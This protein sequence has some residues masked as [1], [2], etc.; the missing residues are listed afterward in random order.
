ML[1]IT[2]ER[3]KEILVQA[4]ESGWSGCLELK[5]EYADLVLDGMRDSDEGSGTSS[6]TISTSDN[7]LFSQHYSYC[8]YNVSG[9][10]VLVNDPEEEI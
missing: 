7:D 10:T 8:G 4:Y 1:R 5:E 3:L 9:S 6:L 2:R